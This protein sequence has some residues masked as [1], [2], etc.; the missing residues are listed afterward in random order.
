LP[1]MAGMYD[2]D[3]FTVVTS[4]DEEYFAGTTP[5][6]SKPPVAC[7]SNKTP[8]ALRA[9]DLFPRDDNE[10]CV[11]C[12][13]N[14]KLACDDSCNAA[15]GWECKQVIKV[16]NCRECP[17]TKCVRAD[18][19]G[20][21]QQ[22]GVTGN[23]SGGAPSV[24]IIIGAVV[25][26]LA[27]IAAITFLVWWFCIRKKR[28]ASGEVVY[29]EVLEQKA[30]TVPSIHDRRDQ[31]SSM[32]TVHSI[33][34]TVLTRASNIIQIAYI[35]GVTNRAAPTSPNVLVPPVPPI[36]I[37]VSDA[38][39]PMPFGEQHFFMPGDLRDSTYSA[40]TGYTDRTSMARTSYAPRSSVASTL[41]G[42]NLVIATPET[43]RVIKPGM[44]SVRSGPGSSGSATPPV[45]AVDYDKY[46]PRN[47]QESYFS[48]GDALTKKATAAP[49][50]TARIVRTGS[51]KIVTVRGKDKSEGDSTSSPSHSSAPS[52][53]SPLSRESTAPT[54]PED[55]S[56]EGPFSDPPANRRTSLKSTKSLSAVIEEA[57][58]R[59]AQVD[60][61]KRLSRETS[62]FGDE[63]AT[64]DSD[65]A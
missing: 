31:R 56:K 63:H 15:E 36:P 46:N 38:N 37:T 4:S 40:M 1:N 47:S 57:T 59:A 25:G 6:H 45:P 55:E 33:A 58:R 49:V 39:S 29:D 42:K 48:I 24:G 20:D 54:I 7:M 35:P 18:G 32:H 2:H 34:S 62:P 43:A 52:V 61:T 51:R 28:Q 12:D 19:A 60:K 10:V 22:N 21:F 16:D 27:G 11:V 26:G 5:P 13:K 50:Q 3:I 14:G 9:R 8:T 41:Y 17:S 30:E 65:S 64:K 53:R 23:K 44:L